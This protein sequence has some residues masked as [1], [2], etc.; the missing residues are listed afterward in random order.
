MANIQK[1]HDDFEKD[2]KDTI[3]N[4][5]TLSKAYDDGSE[6]IAKLIA[7][8][9]RV[10]IHDTNSST[11]L[12]KHLNKKQI[13]FFDT[14]NY[15][16]NNLL[17]EIP[18]VI[19]RIGRGSSK[20]ISGS[21]HPALDQGPPLPVKKVHFDDWWEHS[22]VLRDKSGIELNRKSLVLEVSNKEGGAHV[23]EKVKKHIYKLLRENTTGWGLV[24]NGTLKDFYNTPA[25]PTIRQ[26]AHELLMTLKPE[27]PDY[28]DGSYPYSLEPPT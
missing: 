19:M 6:E 24:E 22:V 13:L 20:N 15:N 26:I 1:T 8:A 9:I 16:P 5:V 12:L 2:L 10:L 14:S 3:Q 27:F 7:V 21:F 17:T 23:D 4:L 28:F 11:S 18:M 25:F